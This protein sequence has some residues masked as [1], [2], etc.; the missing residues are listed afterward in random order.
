MKQS[1]GHATMAKEAYSTLI[2]DLD[3]T[4]YQSPELLE[5]RTEG[6]GERGFRYIVAGKRACIARKPVSNP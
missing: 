4:L 3:S 5:Y 1:R 6:T 2:F